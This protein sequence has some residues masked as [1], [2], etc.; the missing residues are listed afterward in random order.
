[1]EQ[2]FGLANISLIQKQ[3]S[4]NFYIKIGD[5]LELIKKDKFE[6]KIAYDNWNLKNNHM[7]YENESQGENVIFIE[8]KFNKIAPLWY[9]LNSIQNKWVDIIRKTPSLN[10]HE[11][12]DVE[13]VKNKY[14][15][16]DDF[17]KVVN[18]DL[19]KIMV[20]RNKVRGQDNVVVD[21]SEDEIELLYVFVL[22]DLN[23]KL[24]QFKQN[25]KT[26]KFK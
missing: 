7:Y 8:E 22:M 14:I 3:N 20:K 10:I 1:M 26:S 9:Y 12:Y 21:D 17:K 15:V 19:T 16:S 18:D 4:K 2:Q 24:N 25:S 13:N 11:D 23:D 6:N 5:L